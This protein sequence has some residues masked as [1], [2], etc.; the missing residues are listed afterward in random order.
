MAQIDRTDRWASNGRPRTKSH[1]GLHLKVSPD[2]A[3]HEFVSRGC[4]AV[5][6]VAAV[7]EL[8]SYKPGVEFNDILR[9]S[10]TENPR[11][12]LLLMALS[13][14]RDRQ[15]RMIEISSASHPPRSSSKGGL[16]QHGPPIPRVSLP[17][18][19]DRQLWM[20]SSA[21]CSSTSGASNGAIL[22]E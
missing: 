6:S 19:E 20:T 8:C 14:N 15:D 10:R 22:F 12:S 2:T 1:S 7:P 17:H 16:S 9:K 4:H 11:S 13:T 18:P 21:C 3:P 5:T